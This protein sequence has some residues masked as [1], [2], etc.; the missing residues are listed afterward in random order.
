MKIAILSYGA[1][2]VASVQYAL[3]RLGIES[4]ISGDPKEL[5][6]ADKLIFPGVGHASHAMQSLAQR[7]LD[8]FLKDFDRPLLGICLGMQLMGRY[9]EEGSTAGL[10]LMDFDVKLFRIDQKVPHMGWNSVEINDNLLF[11]GIPNGSH[12][13]FVHSYFAEICPETTVSCNYSIPFTAAV[14]NGNR[15]GVQFHP[16]ISGEMGNELLE[17]FINLCF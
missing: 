11:K 15:Y 5:N 6:M 7:G 2:N 13:Y 1:G 12:F 10:G 3:D 17:N 4:F 16:E 8:K 9:S 14:Q